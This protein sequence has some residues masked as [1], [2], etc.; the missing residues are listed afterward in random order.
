MM[1]VTA[2]AT[3]GQLAD[4]AEGRLFVGRAAQLRDFETLLGQLPQRPGAIYVCGPAGIGKSALLR[5]FARCA[6]AHEIPSLALDAAASPE[7]GNR[8]AAAV[9]ALAARLLG[10]EAPAEADAAAAAAAEHLH[11]LARTRPHLLLLDGYDSLQGGEAWF[12]ERFLTRVGAGVG[13][14]LAGREPAARLWADAAPWRSTVREMGLEPLTAQEVAALLDL[15]Q[16]TAPA[17]RA[18]ILELAGGHPRLLGRAVA[19]AAAEPAWAESVAQSQPDR[20][21]LFLVERVLH[22]GSRRRAWRAA[23][24]DEVVAA[25]S[26][27]PRFDRPALAAALGRAPVDR[28][29]SVLLDLAGAAAAGRGAFPEPFR[30]RLELAVRLQRP[31]MEERWRRRIMEH[32]IRRAQQGQPGDDPAE[33]WQAFVRLAREAR[34]HAALHPAQEGGGWT[35]VWSRSA[36]A[37]GP[38]WRL[39]VRDPAGSL[40]G[41]AVGGLLGAGAQDWPA[42]AAAFL[43]AGQAGGGPPAG[44][45]LVAF[46][47]P[48]GPLRPAVEG[49]LLREAARAFAHRGQIVALGL[50]AAE[51]WPGG[52]SPLVAL[53]FRREEGLPESWRLEFGAGG[54]AEWLRHVSAAPPAP[55]PEHWAAAAKEALAALPEPSDLAATLAGRRFRALR[56]PAAGPAAARSWVLDAVASCG[57]QPSQEAIVINYYLE[58]AGSHEAVAERLGLPRATYYRLHR[59]ALQHIGEA[60][61]R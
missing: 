50:C 23:G 47:A 14:V 30:R 49:V 4:D 3:L 59:L 6:D 16:V 7:P 43:D 45:L 22:P 55:A 52:E 44:A 51:A 34:C 12:R 17:V 18:A 5:A 58:R 33:D 40:L 39:C 15:Q 41:S 21:A 35:C 25:A 61:L 9:R 29:W 13:V 53:G 56:G 1:P 27:L 36:A 46:E 10:G 48:P 31:W 38:Q 60:L 8:G 54:Y 57:L 20:L 19:A 2:P 11:R 37:C 24:S 32:L 42:P 26:L 28:G